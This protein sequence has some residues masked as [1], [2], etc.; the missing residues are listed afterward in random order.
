M[1]YSIAY[2]LGT[3]INSPLCSDKNVRCAD[4]G[5]AFLWQFLLAVPHSAYYC[6]NRIQNYAHRRHVCKLLEVVYII[7][8][9][10]GLGYYYGIRN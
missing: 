5:E 9:L 7:L 6:R 4:V 8:P 2:E 1:L 3:Y 10:P